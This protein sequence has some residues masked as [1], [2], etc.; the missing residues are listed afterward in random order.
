LDEVGGAKRIICGDRRLADKAMF[1]GSGLNGRRMKADLEDGA[2]NGGI[3]RKEE[4]EEKL[5][6]LVERLKKDKSIR[7]ILLFG[8]MARGDVGSASDIDLIIV[9]ETDKKFLDRLDEFYE[10]AEIAMDVLVYTPEEFERMKDRGFIRR[11][12]EEGKVLYEAGFA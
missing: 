3:R 1:A 8:S 7:L 11:A 10:G 12:I 5:K 6:K 4:L 2:S 9:K